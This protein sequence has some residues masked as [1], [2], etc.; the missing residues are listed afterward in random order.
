MKYE[1]QRPSGQ[2]KQIPVY[3]FAMNQEEAELLLGTVKKVKD[4]FPKTPETERAHQ[5]LRT[6][7]FC[8][9]RF[10]VEELKKKD[11]WF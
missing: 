2:D 5:R 7:Y 10:V 9:R 8:L 1:G 4:L 3:L 6:I 11:G